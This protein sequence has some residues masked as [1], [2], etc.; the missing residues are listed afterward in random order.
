VDLLDNF[1]NKGC[2]ERFYDIARTENGSD[3]EKKTTGKPY[4]AIL[5]A[6]GEGG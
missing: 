2:G 3:K 4:T 5:V 1:M 6:G